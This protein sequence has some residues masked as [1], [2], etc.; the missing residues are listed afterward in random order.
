[1]A[2]RGPAPKAAE[3]RRNHHAPARG[4]WVD[5]PVNGRKGAP[6]KLP[7]MRKW[8]KVTLAWW[9]AIWSTPEATMWDE[10][11]GELVRLAVLH[12]LFAEAPSAAIS[13]EMRQIEDRH[14]MNE[15]GRRDLRWRI[16]APVEP[17]PA[18]S[19]RRGNVVRPDRWQQL[20]V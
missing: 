5:L 6:P 7:P 9:A 13:G 11:D 12:E 15:K 19:T 3:Q 1:M 17:E 14:G 20:G 16:A 10:R 8:S 2:G 18:K 4:E